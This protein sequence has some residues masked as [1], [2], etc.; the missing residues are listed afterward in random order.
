MFRL[1]AVVAIAGVSLGWPTLV[2]AAPA[3]PAADSDGPA[4]ALSKTVYVG[5]DDGARCSEAT[6]FAE[7]DPDTTVTYCFT[8]T[9]TGTTHLTQVSLNDPHVPAPIVALSEG[10]GLL[11]PGAQA[12]FYVV[13]TPPPDDADGLVDDTFT[14]VASVSAVAAD[15]DGQVVDGAQPV[16][17]SGEAVVFRPEE[18]LEPAVGLATSV[19]AG[20]LGGEGCPAADL[21]LVG[22]GELITYCY[23]VTNEGNTHLGA[24]TLTQ[25]GEAV[26]PTLIRTE[27]TADGR[28]APGQSAWY[29]LESTSPDPGTGGVSVSGTVTANPVDTAG[30]D[31]AGVD[32]VTVA[33][34]TRI[35][36]PAGGAEAPV[37]D[38]TRTTASKPDWAEATGPSLMA[39]EASGAEAPQALAH[40]GL[41]TWLL[42]TAGIGLVAGGVA[43]VQEAAFRRR[44]P[45]PVPVPTRGPLRSTDTPNRS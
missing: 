17:A 23:T 9:N 12:Q 31:L 10:S 18:R 28:L 29:H 11:A 45:V 14:N 3:A 39:Q 37:P 42:A 16:T 43:L 6:S 30:A 41:E 26:T 34:P 33:D 1:L 20:H 27:G 32:D 4:V 38:S 19:H 25:A 8:V 36:P 21:T 7:A 13:A 2:D 15:G 44:P 24:I 35:E 5:A 40:T 22:A